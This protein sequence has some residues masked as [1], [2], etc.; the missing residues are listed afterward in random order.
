[1]LGI[2]LKLLGI[3]KAILGW[4]LGIIQQGFEWAQNH[5]LLAL[6]I[7]VD[8]ALL[9]GCW[10]GYGQHR[11]SQAKSVTIT[12]LQGEVKQKDSLI[13]QLYERIKEYAAALEQTEAAREADIKQHNEAVDSIKKAADQQI[14]DAQRKA[15]ETKK[16]RDAYF[17]LSQ[18]YRQA[19]T[20]GGTPEQRIANEEQLNR[21]FIRDMQGVK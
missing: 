8:V 6:A 4:F 1:M 17:L 19:I 14:A 5:P 20:K 18:K 9:A 16:E 10:W 2:A 21:E 12:Q 3:G 13:D 11:D 15:A 7:V